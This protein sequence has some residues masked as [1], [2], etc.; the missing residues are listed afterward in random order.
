M[1]LTRAPAL[2]PDGAYGSLR[3]L[4][5][6][7]HCSDLLLLRASR[8]GPTLRALVRTSPIA[9]PSSAKARSTS[10]WWSLDMTA[11]TRATSRSAHTTSLA[12]R[13]IR[14]KSVFMRDEQSWRDLIIEAGATPPAL[15]DQRFRDWMTRQRIFVSSVMDDEMRPAREAVRQWV[16]SWD[17]AP[18]MWEELAPRDQHPRRAY[19]EGVDRSTIYVLLAGTSY[20]V[21]DESGFSPTH[22][23]GERAKE[24]G[25]PRL[26]MNKADVPR[27]RRDG[28]LNRWI[29]SLYNE[30]SAGE[31]IT[32]EEVTRALERR[33]REMASAQATPWIK[34]G[35]LVF[36]GRV[37]RRG[38]Y[39]GEITVTAR[40]RDG[41]LRR[42]LSGL[43][44]F[45]SRFR[46]DRLTWADETHPVRVTDTQVET[47]FTSEDEVTITCAFPQ[48][49][50]G[51]DAG[52]TPVSYGSDG[53]IDRQVEIWARHML[54]GTPLDRSRHRHDMLV[55]MSV[56]DG[57]P[58]L[59]E[60]LR[61][62]QAQGWLAEGLARLNLVEELVSRHGGHFQRLEVG[63]ATAAGVRIDALYL[64]SSHRGAPISIS[65]S[66][67]LR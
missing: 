54:F 27:N 64:P 57:V 1:L 38:G 6:D 45:S 9:D 8:G 53:G 17:A 42:A 60:V 55:L 46:A 31:Y 20:G 36:P 30:V 29:S 50:F 11:L 14:I 37:I 48:Q 34:L 22:Q 7:D 25:I 13:P 56:P 49:Y 66:V 18:E 19:L 24:R 16:T 32:P 58:T 2:K 5:E 35:Q 59:P 40:V 12:F 39:Q 47:S 51:P 21:Q 52:V 4:G 62:Y 63:P 3:K 44:H 10:F 33:L 43:G 28:Y 67:P 23:E 15:D 26:L 61:R 65:G 41:S